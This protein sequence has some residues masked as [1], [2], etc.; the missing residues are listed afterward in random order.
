VKELLLQNRQGEQDEL[1]DPKVSAPDR[2]QFLHRPASS[3][4]S[5]ENENSAEA[6]G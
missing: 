1:A 6:L 3:K 5:S 2:Q 4:L